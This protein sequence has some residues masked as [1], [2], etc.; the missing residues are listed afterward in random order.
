[1]SANARPRQLTERERQRLERV[2]A[3]EHQPRSVRHDEVQ[4]LARVDENAITKAVRE[5]EAKEKANT[6]ALIV[7]LITHVEGK[8]GEIRTRLRDSRGLD[9]RRYRDL[10]NIR[11]TLRQLREA[12][13]TDST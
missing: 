9:R 6:D 5:R 11:R 7:Q 12:L 3:Y 2:L 8:L 4:R 1:M 13:E 10:D